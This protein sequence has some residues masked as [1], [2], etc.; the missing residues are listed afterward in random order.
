MTRSKFHSEFIRSGSVISLV[1]GNL[2]I[3]WGKRQ[4]LSSP[5]HSQEPAFYSPDFFL[6]EQLPWFFHEQYKIVDPK[7]FINELLPFSE[8]VSAKYSWKNPHRGFFESTFA[9]LKN[10]FEAKEL[11]KAVPFV[12]E[13]ANA[14]FDVDQLNCSL[15]NILKYVHSNKVYLYGFWDEE[16]GILG[17]TPELLFRFTKREKHHLETMACAST[18]PSQSNIE[19]L[20]SDPKELHEHSVVVQ[21]ITESLTP[22]GKVNVGKIKLLELPRLAHLLTPISVE[23]Y[24]NPN[25]NAIVRALHPTPA[26]GAFPKEKG[27]RWL[28]E[29]QMQID[30][31]RY[32]APVGYWFQQRGDASCYVAIRNAQWNPNGI[33]IGAGCGV[34]AES[35]LENEWEEINL[36]IQAIKELL[37]L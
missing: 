28:E 6:N 20:L 17:A 12:F 32:G 26:L 37:A 29:M 18:R 21:G 36:K 8:K 11:D 24:E 2:L 25:F 23:L 15:I 30:R 9:H 19:L 34:V 22:F 13:Y 35:L 27:N 16:R 14:R 31:G 5:P 7:D 3:G 4:W 33:S 1:D 10:H